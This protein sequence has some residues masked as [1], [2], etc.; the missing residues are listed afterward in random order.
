MSKQKRPP[1]S[2][3]CRSISLL[4]QIGGLDGKELGCNMGDSS[5]IPG[6]GRSPGEGNGYFWVLKFCSID[7]FVYSSANSSTNSTVY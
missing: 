7:V 4:S 2:D 1:L 5:S 3:W 6:L